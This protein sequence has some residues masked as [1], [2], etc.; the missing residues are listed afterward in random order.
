[1][2]VCGLA[3]SPLVPLNKQLW[4]PSYGLLTGGVATLLNAIF[5]GL[6]DSDAMYPARAMTVTGFL[7]RLFAPL[8]WLGANAIIFFVL[9]DCC[10][11]ASHLLG[12]IS[13]GLPS[14]DKNVIAWFQNTVLMRW[15]HLSEH[16]SGTFDS[17]APAVMAFVLVELAFWVA[18]CCMLHRRGVFWK[19]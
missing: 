9:S 6:V 7:R 4:S 19:I 2:T 18:V 16:C 15:L 1:L 3:L 12:G 11:W 17:C 5:F 14:K 10:G 13:W 8:Q